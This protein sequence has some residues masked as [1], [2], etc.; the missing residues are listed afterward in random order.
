MR[1]KLVIISLSFLCLI[2]AFS[3]LFIKNQVHSDTLVISDFTKIEY[4]EGMYLGTK[5]EDGVIKY[6]GAGSSYC[7]PIAKQAIIDSN[8]RYVITIKSY[9]N[10]IC[11]TDYSP[12]VQTIS[13]EDGKK[14]PD[15]SVILVKR[16]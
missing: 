12:F 7:R 5:V 10:D 2:S 4:S 1:N 13:R 3:L 11:T 8:D 14:I 15:N 6:Y 9:E 16:N